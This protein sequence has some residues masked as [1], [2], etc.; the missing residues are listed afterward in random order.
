MFFLLF[1][2][3]IVSSGSGCSNASECSNASKFRH[4][5]IDVIMD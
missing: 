5:E 2:I 4:S 1:H 3:I